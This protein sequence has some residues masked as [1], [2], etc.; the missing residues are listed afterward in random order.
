MIRSIEWSDDAKETFDVIV[1]IIENKWSTR[2]AGVFIKRVRRVLQMIAM[3]PEMY[4]ASISADVRQA[5]I[6]KQTSMFYKVEE[7]SIIV[8]YFW[9]NRQEPL[10]E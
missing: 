8:L 4:K 9:D 2:Q 10:F 7:R 1:L 5:V 3:H 6:S